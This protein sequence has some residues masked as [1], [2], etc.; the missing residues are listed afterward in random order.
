MIEGL[1]ATVA[2]H[3]PFHDLAAA[4]IKERDFLAKY[5]PA[6][7]DQAQIDERLRVVLIE[8]GEK[9]HIGKVLKAFFET[10]DRN[11][12]DGQLVSARAKALIAGEQ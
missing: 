11:A 6:Q 7:L 2:A 9:P 5:L 8:A 12:V 4:E 1:A 10:V 3:D